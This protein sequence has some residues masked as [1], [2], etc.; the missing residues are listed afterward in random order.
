MRVGLSPVRPVD[1]PV[2]ATPVGTTPRADECPVDDAVFADARGCVDDLVTTR[3]K[4][5]C[6]EKHVRPAR[7]RSVDS[8]CSS[9]R[10]A[11][12]SSGGRAAPHRGR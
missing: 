12:S 10:P 3:Q 8:R 7:R 11:A 4:Q 1:V 6:S 5:H 9:V 2:N